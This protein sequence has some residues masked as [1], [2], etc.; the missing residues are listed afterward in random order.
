MKYRLKYGKLIL[1]FKLFIKEKNMDGSI[2]YAEYTVEQKAEGKF[3]KRKLLWLAVY[4]LIIFVYIGIMVKLSNYGVLVAILTVPFIPLTVMVAKHFTWNRFVKIEHKY[5]VVNAKLKI[6]EVY[7][8]KREVVVFENLLSEFSS[9]GPMDE[10][11][12]DKWSNADKILDCRG[13]YKS[14]ESYYA[15]LEKDGKTVVVRFEAINKMIKSMK[16]YNSS[17]TIVKQMRF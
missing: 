15:R 11:Y 10:E 2:N 6:S 4:G 16:F 7:G 13:S 1:S 12:K 5:E 8:P 14:P 9:I 3:L 17:A